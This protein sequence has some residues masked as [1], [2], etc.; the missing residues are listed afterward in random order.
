MMTMENTKGYTQAV[1]DTLNAEFEA[2]FERGDWPTSE[3]DE[4]SQWFADEIS[5]R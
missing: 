3:R 5:R 2:R 4:A 1:L